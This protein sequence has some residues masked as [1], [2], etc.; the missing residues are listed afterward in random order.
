M[1]LIP[2]IKLISLDCTFSVHMELIP[3]I[4]LISLDCTFS[5]HMELIPNIAQSKKKYI[6]NYPLTFYFYGLQY[7]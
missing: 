3:G 4:K 5:V 6:F 1:E 2:G 7:T